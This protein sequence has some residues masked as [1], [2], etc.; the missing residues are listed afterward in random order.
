[1]TAPTTPERTVPASQTRWPAV[2]G[3]ALALFMA[4]LD[5]T[6]VSVVLPVI[7]RSLHAA[8]QHTQ[9]VM[10]AYFLPAVALAIPAGRWIDHAGPRAAFQVAVLAFG[11]SSALVAAAPALPAMV[12]ARA[13]QGVFAG[14]IGPVVL[15]VVA[16]AVLPADRGRA[17]GVAQSSQCDSGRRSSLS[18]DAKYACGASRRARSRRFRSSAASSGFTGLISMP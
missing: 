5:M 3:S 17:L 10:L 16:T 18:S 4:T 2:A 6:I 7:G 12:A 9:W 8:P 13:L 11:A 15:A 1:V 14:L